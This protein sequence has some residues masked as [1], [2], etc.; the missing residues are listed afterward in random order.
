MLWEKESGGDSIRR[1][2]REGLTSGTDEVSVKPEE[3]DIK[4]EESHQIIQFSQ[5]PLNQFLAIE[6]GIQ[7]F[8]Q[9]YT[10][11]I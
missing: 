2:S 10:L 4:N 6:K 11:V 9:L 1:I 5:V 8:W 7:T 3:A